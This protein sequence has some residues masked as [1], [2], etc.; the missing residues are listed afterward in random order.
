MPYMIQSLTDLASWSSLAN[1]TLSGDTV[2][3]TNA[4]NASVP[5][6]ILARGVAAVPA[7]LRGSF[8]R[9]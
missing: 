3:V 8:R 7:V 4:V 2:N 5:G 9:R 1:N 6:A